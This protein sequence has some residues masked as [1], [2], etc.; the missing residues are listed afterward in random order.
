MNKINYPQ[1]P[2]ELISFKQAYYDCL[3]KSKTD[4]INKH[5]KKIRAT[6]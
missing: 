5:L 6:Y 4:E 1:D 2:N 3:D